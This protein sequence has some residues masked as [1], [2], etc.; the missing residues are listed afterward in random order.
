[1]EIE[2]RPVVAKGEDGEERDGVG[3]WDQ[4]I[5]NITLRKDKQQGPTA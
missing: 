4:Y 1:M 2:S 3:I 5:Q